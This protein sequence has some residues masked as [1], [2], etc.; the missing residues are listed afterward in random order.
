MDMQASQAE[1]LSDVA[2]HGALAADQWAPVPVLRRRA[3]T[4]V[5]R[6]RHVAAVRELCAGGA[7]RRDG[8][9]LPPSREGLR[10]CLAGAARGVRRLPTRSSASTRTS[11]RTLIPGSPMPGATSRWRSSDSGLIANSL[12]V[13]LASNDGYLLQHVVER[14]I[15]ALGIEPAA[16]VARVAREQGHRDGRRVLRPGSGSSARGRGPRR[17]ST[18]RQQRH[19]PR[20]RPQRLRR[21]HLRSCWR[22]RASRR[23][24]FRTC[25]ASSRA[26]SSTRSTTSTS[27][28]SRC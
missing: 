3:R 9:V 16:N 12:V 13:E 26:T 28:T 22:R 5:R 8:A 10:E 23:S 14:G 1:I 18:G 24:R 15:P 25:F 6:P 17:R 4:H 27:P 20:S 21:R 11:P 19:G 7:R 2:P